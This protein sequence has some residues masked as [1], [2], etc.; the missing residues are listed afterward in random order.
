MF[1]FNERAIL[2]IKKHASD[3]LLMVLGSTNE[4]GREGGDG[5]S[6]YCNNSVSH[7]SRFNAGLD[8]RRRYCSLLQQTLSSLNKQSDNVLSTYTTLFYSLILFVIRAMVVVCGVCAFFFL[9]IRSK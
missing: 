6:E 8:R 5:S 4:R 3:Y 9:F 7:S 1:L 2:L